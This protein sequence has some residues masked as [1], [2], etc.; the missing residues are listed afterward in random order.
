MAS[1]LAHLEFELGDP[2][3]N[4]QG[5]KLS[6]RGHYNITL[7]YFYFTFC[8][9]C[10]Q[11]IG[12]LSCNRIALKH[13]SI[14]ESSGIS[15][16]TATEHYYYTT[17]TDIKNYYNYILLL[18]QLDSKYQKRQSFFLLK[19]RVREFRDRLVTQQPGDS[20]ARAKH[21]TSILSYF[22]EHKY[23]RKYEQLFNRYKYRKFSAKG[24]SPTKL[25]PD[26]F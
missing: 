3:S 22:T 4:P 16:T 14:L 2:D 21:V 9:H 15:T 7:L 17:T 5:F 20:T 24:S 6:F 13:L 8:S 12:K 26:A 19:F 11:A 18:L 23:L 10:S 1:W 25:F